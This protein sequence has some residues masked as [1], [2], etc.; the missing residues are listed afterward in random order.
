MTP[1]A[2]FSPVLLFLLFAGLAACAQPEPPDAPDAPE[3]AEAPD[4]PAPI[5]A[6]AGLAVPPRAEGEAR[7]SPNAAVSQTIGTTQVY[8]SYGRPGVKGRRVFGDLEAYGQVW[9]AGAN[10]ATVIS[11]S[12]G[13]TVEGQPLDAGAYAL[14]AIPG[15]DEWTLI[16]NR[17]A[18][19]WGAF[20]HD[21]AQDALR[22]TV[23]PEEAAAQE[24]LSYSFDDLTDT[25]A[26]A[27]LHWSTTRVPF[28]ISTP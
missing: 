16:F 25:S 6:V 23:T 24:W 15:E 9:R 27:A 14:F 5:T 7:P 12:D 1:R 3:A 10:E 2:L 20:D 13:V 11:F 4:V 8:I 17:Q 19:Q 28:T 21:E 18:E 22:V 26:T